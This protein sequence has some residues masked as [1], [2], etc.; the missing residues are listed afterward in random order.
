[1]RVPITHTRHIARHSAVTSIP[2]MS[3]TNSKPCR[4]HDPKPEFTDCMEPKGRLDRMRLQIRSPRCL[5]FQYTCSFFIG[6]RG[7][8]NAYA[9]YKF[10]TNVFYHSEQ[11]R[12]PTEITRYRQHVVTLPSTVIG[13]WVNFRDSPSFCSVCTRASSACS[14]NTC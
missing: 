10:G 5:D 9:S 2:G 1:V 8:Q 4:N 6:V 3:L 14:A 12:L 13:G 7:N 11:L